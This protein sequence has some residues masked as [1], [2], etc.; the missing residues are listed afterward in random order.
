[1]LYEPIFI[2]PPLMLMKN[3]TK[4]YT[5][6]MISFISLLSFAQPTMV[7]DIFEGTN[8]ASPT[9]FTTHNN[10]LY[11]TIRDTLNP[12]NANFLYESDGTGSGTNKLPNTGYMT[13]ITTFGNKILFS[14]DPTGGT[15]Y[16]PWITDG[17]IAG[18]ILLKEMNPGFKGSSPNFITLNNQTAFIYN[19]YGIFKTNGT[20]SGTSL[21]L[22]IIMSNKVIAFKNK[23][24]FWGTYN[25]LQGLW[26]FD[27]NATAP[28]L[29][30]QHTNSTYNFALSV[31]ANS[32]YYVATDAEHGYEPWVSDGTAAGTHLLKDIKP[33]TASSC[34]DGS[35]SS[36]TSFAIV[37]DKVYFNPTEN[38]YGRELWVS[39]GT[40]AGTNL[41]FEL[42]PGATSGNPRKL[43]STGNQFYFAARYPGYNT[44]FVWVSDL[45]AA[46][47]KIVTDKN[48]AFIEEGGMFALNN[49]LFV[50][51][52]DR[53]NQ[54]LGFEPFITDGTKMGTYMLA[55]IDSTPYAESISST[56]NQLPFVIGNTIYFVANDAVHGNELWKYTDN[57]TGG[58]QVKEVK[59]VRNISIYPNPA[60]NQLNVT[61]TENINK[62]ELYNITGLLALS[63]TETTIDI[64]SLN[65][66]IY[67]VR[68]YTIQGITTQKIIKN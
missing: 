1:M 40:E 25:S 60:Q 66:G 30:A 55:D 43:I 7:K 52:R 3:I 42:I 29:M 53:S 62:T 12:N 65:Q 51:G 8:G 9:N 63:T 67:F 24:Y 56:F 45:T 16:E 31:G 4:V 44:D 11:F 68:V 21:F 35:S 15:N 17:T 48:D 49:K 34:D 13:N 59:S 28:T 39:N 32:F 37:N 33:G 50:K 57:G 61:S 64:S 2:S 6:L 36:Y 46:G 18:T 38:T 19:G 47:T 54:I 41:F 20:P 58:T 23:I 14:G 10:K 5:T 22:P 26:S 27:E